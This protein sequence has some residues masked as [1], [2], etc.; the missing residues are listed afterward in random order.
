MEYRITRNDNHLEHHGI[1]GQHWGIR[2]FQNEDGSLTAKG[3]EHYG[4]SEDSS[5]KKSKIGSFISRHKKG[6]AIAG[7]L[8]AAGVAAVAISQ[9]ANNKSV[10][11][12]SE[13]TQKILT[14]HKI[15]LEVPRT[16]VPRVAVPKTTVPKVDT[17][18]MQKN[19]DHFKRNAGKVMKRNQRAIQEFDRLNDEVVK[20]FWN[21]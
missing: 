17:R 8:L 4:V 6:L 21:H 5:S 3:K 15:A 16:E 9:I 7:G 1:K 18:A 13:A 11:K 14:E 20:K 12:G 2:R 19:A 10:Q